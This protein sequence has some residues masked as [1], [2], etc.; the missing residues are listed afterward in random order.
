MQRDF[1]ELRDGR[2]FDMSDYKVIV[3]H[4]GQQHSFRVA[5]A[6][7]K[8][9]LL[10]KYITEVYDK[11]NVVMKLAHR[12]VRGKDTGKI[13]N[14]RC[15][16]L[17]DEDV[18]LYDTLLS[19][20][21]IVLSRKS[22]TRKLSYWLD[23]KIADAFGKKVAKYAVKN[24]V[25]AVI[26]FS[27]NETVCF[28]YLRKHAPE[29]KRIVDCANAPVDYM[30][31]IYELDM[32]RTG[33]PVL[34]T[35]AAA[36][37]DVKELY[38]QQKGIDATGH[39]LAPSEFVKKGLVFCGAEKN[40]VHIL[41]YGANF[42]P[43]AAPQKEIGQVRFIYVGQVTYRKGL[44]DLLK[45]FSELADEGVFLDVVGA[46]KSP[47]DLYQ[48]YKNCE[49]ITFHGNVVHEKVQEL[50]LA[51]N[52]FVF[53][54]LTEG[55]SLSCL[56]ALSCGLPV[57]CSRNSGANDIIEEGVNGFTFEAGDTEALKRY[58]LF[59]QNNPE[60]IAEFSGNAIA[61]AKKNTWLAYGKNLE[62]IVRDILK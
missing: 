62:K 21:V 14:R 13:K 46:W 26:C 34:K 22:R 5:G 18:I 57:I 2:S 51:S 54:S 11:P 42:T 20:A 6:L 59:F 60:K 47:S 44:H 49:N 45:V 17:D 48:R 37:W 40:F 50:M 33:S 3:A 15:G 43:V 55:F 4:P 10:F 35:E 24:K 52:V 31:Q 29:M 32:E 39:F 9:G 38:K 16:E 28:E 58:V 27:M 8:E 12:L 41:H 56:E 36:F 30:R 7:K 23:R 25:D 53:A 19:L 1:Q 61:S